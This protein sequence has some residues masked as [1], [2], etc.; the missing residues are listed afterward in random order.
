MTWS[1][2]R[3]N[4]DLYLVD[5][6]YSQRRDAEIENDLIRTFKLFNFE[7]E[8]FKRF[9]SNKKIGY[10]YN[11]PDLKNFFWQKYT[12]NSSYIYQNS[13]D[14]DKDV[15]NFIKSSSPYYSHQFA[16]PNFE[17][18]RLV[19]KFKS[20]QLNTNNIP[21]VIINNKVHP[22]FQKVKIDYNVYCMK[23][24]GEELDLYILK[25]YCD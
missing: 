8:F 2:L 7:V 10:R 4:L 15:L 13:T 9:I 24:E 1:I 3:E 22:I 11:N 25:Q 16:I 18:S 19:K 12:A 17:I 21:D 23:F 14:F 20:Y 6:T 5:G